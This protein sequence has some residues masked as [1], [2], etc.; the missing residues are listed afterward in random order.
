LTR[1][2]GTSIKNFTLKLIIQELLR[3]YN[4]DVFS[5]LTKTKA[6]FM[7]S[8]DKVAFNIDSLTIHLTLNILVQ[9]SLPSLPNLSL[10]SLNKLTCQYEQLQLVVIDEISLVGAKMF[11]V[12]Y[13]RLRSIKNIQNKFFGGVDVIIT[14]DTSNTLCER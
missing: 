8:I 4:R 3:L 12:I 11:D 1:G 7:A 2:V 14:S 13:N 5:N 6:L 10:D 9:Q